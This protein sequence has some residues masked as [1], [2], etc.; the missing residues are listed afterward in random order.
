MELKPKFTHDC[1][2]C[3]FL[4]HWLGNDVYFCR[5]SPSQ[6]L[7]ARSS[8]EPDDYYSVSRHLFM[9]HGFE[10]GNFTIAV[11]DRVV[12]FSEFLL[13]HPPLRSITLALALRGLNGL[14][15]PTWVENA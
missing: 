7:I 2:D 12:P 1:A 4:G 8:D 5:D 6:S 14:P 3:E 10:E 15:M 13:E 11:S 9:K